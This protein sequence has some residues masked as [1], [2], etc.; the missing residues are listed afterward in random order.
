MS[1]FSSKKTKNPL[2]FL[3]SKH[4]DYYWKQTLTYM[5]LLVVVVF[6]GN[7]I[8]KNSS[9]YS[10]Q[11]GFEQKQ[12]FVL[13]LQESSYDPFYA[14]IYDQI[15]PVSSDSIQQVIQYIENETQPSKDKSTFL[16]VGCGTGKCIQYL[17]KK[18]YKVAGIDRSSA[19]VSE[20]Q[21]KCGFKV[22]FQNKNVLE[23]AR[24][25]EEDDFSHILCL[26]PTTLYEICSPTSTL[27]KQDA[28]KVSHNN[29]RKF[30]KHVHKWLRRG[31]YFIVQIEPMTTLSQSWVSVTGDKTTYYPNF[32]KRVNH[33]DPYTTEIRFSEVDYKLEMTPSVPSFPSTE[34]RFLGTDRKNKLKTQYAQ[35]DQHHL[36]PVSN[37]FS[38][39]IVE[40]NPS[41]RAETVVL[42]ETFANRHSPQVRQ[43][44]W[45]LTSPYSD[46]QDWVQAIERHGFGLSKA[47]AIPYPS[48]ANNS[49]DTHSPIPQIYLF[50]KL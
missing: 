13:E 20:A 3:W 39:S 30:L 38:S 10:N 4:P 44:E 24:I 29:L 31:G 2:A 14:E 19:M 26:G 49:T 18:G 11:E 15:H 47:G 34:S 1:F 21:E 5:S 48:P 35:D 46:I 37:S 40:N 9:L 42:Q 33:P 22:P 12:D 8:T 43:N 23:S 25:F 6:I 45:H 41:S 32:P 27:L 7:N 50:Q 36:Q 28:S 16:E 17:Q